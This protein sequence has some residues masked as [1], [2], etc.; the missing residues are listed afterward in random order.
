M[1]LKLDFLTGGCVGISSIYPFGIGICP[2]INLFIHL[3]IH[4]FKLICA[5]IHPDPP[6]RNEIIEH[7]ETLDEI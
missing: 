5:S 7:F 4:S 3:F 1:Q 2:S 6:I